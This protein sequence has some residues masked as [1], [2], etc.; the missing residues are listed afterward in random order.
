[1]QNSDVGSKDKEIQ[2]LI[3]SAVFQAQERER[4][5]I[6]R[7]LHDGI[8]QS[9][10][11]LLLHIE[12]IQSLYERGQDVAPCLEKLK[13]ITLQTIGEVRNLSSEIRPPDLDDEGLIIA[14]KNI[15]GNLGTR[16]AIQINFKYKGFHKRLPQTIENALYRITREA[17]INAAKYSKAERIDVVLE[18]NDDRVLLT[19]T[20]YGEG[21]RFSESRK[22]VGIYSMK[23]RAAI[24]GGN[25][26][27]FSDIGR[28]TKVKAEIP[29]Q[30][31]DEVGK[32]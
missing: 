9:L 2:K 24:L 17:L 13:N 26:A 6:S 5:K 29:I 19:V 32:N 10:Y 7:E 1:M 3:T 23:E 16:F 27:I 14:L 22:G 4:R 15:M 20:D 18:L 30:Q 28:G 12:S 11:G 25:V 31:G 21:F 8:G